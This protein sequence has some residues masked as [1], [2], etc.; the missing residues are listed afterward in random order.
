MGEQSFDQRL[1]RI[2]TRWTQVLEAHGPSADAANAAQALLLQRYGGAVYRYLL[3][4]VRDP[5]VA[6]DLAQEFAVRMLRGDFRRANPAQGRF[7]DYL[8]TALIHLVTDYHR[9]HQQQPRLLSSD[10]PEPAALP[11]E[12][13]DT[14]TNFLATWREEL[15]ERTWKALAEH[16]PAYYAVLRFRVD[17]PDVTS[18]ETAE[19]LSAHLGKPLTGDWVRKTLQRAHA[20]YADLLLDEV[21]FSLGSN[22]LEALQKELRELDLLKYCRAAVAQRGPV[23]RSRS[24]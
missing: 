9:S 7:R 11:D 23:P 5:D 4:A 18:T 8:K 1:S 2:S 20:K 17:H 15:L 21:G 10:A 16:N 3:G 24:G 12:G 14:E 19:Q 22:D 6:E 13:P